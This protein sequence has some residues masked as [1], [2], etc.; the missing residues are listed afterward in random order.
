M[1]KG[2][3]QAISEKKYLQ[4]PVNIRQQNLLKENIS[5]ISPIRVPK[6]KAF[7]KMLGVSEGVRI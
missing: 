7:L 3:K 2:Q 6:V 5:S 1:R 4:K